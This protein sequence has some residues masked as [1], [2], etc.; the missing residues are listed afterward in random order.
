MPQQLVNGQG[1]CH[2]ERL[3]TIKRRAWGSGDY[4]LVVPEFQVF[5]LDGLKEGDEVVVIVRRK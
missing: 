5:E 3:A 4:Y 1:E 2:I